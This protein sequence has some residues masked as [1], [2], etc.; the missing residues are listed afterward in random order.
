[1]HLSTQ[2]KI[3]T[4]MGNRAQAL[5]QCMTI[6]TAGV[7]FTSPPATERACGYDV[8]AGQFLVDGDS[9]EANQCYFN[10]EDYQ[11]YLL[12]SK[13]TMVQ[14]S[15]INIEDEAHKQ[16]DFVGESVAYETG[17]LIVEKKNNSGKNQHHQKQ[18]Q[19]NLT[20]QHQSA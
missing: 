9:G 20:T 12:G 18:T 5:N 16:A 3:I 2:D 7:S 4:M 1:M 10:A 13:Q 15:Y 8:E 17:D 11:Q 19:L 6:S 14:E